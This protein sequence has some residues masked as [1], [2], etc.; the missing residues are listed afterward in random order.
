MNL[1]GFY[2]LFIFYYIFLSRY[3]IVIDAI[4]VSNAV[5]KTPS[6]S[7]KADAHHL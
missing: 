6:H 3:I 2:F 1:S 7:A 5:M 4:S